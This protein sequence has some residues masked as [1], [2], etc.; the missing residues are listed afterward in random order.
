M[1]RCKALLWCSV[2]LVCGQGVAEE[3]S[4][5]NVLFIAMDD[6]NDWTTLFDKDNP[7]KT[8]NMDRLAKRGMFFNKAYSTSAACSPSR[9]A[10]MTGIRPHN[11]GV[12]AL[13]KNIPR[14]FRYPGSDRLL[15]L[16]GQY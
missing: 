6:L 14:P 2:V 9:A 12:Y 5:P 13:L 4:R 11:S 10:I 7:I 8:P 3:K 16:S 1:E 15:H